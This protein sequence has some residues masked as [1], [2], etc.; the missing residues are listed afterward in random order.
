[1]SPN[2]PSCLLL[3]RGNAAK[4]SAIYGC[5]GF[6]RTCSTVAGCWFKGRSSTESCRSRVFSA[7]PQVVVFPRN[8]KTP[9]MN[10]VG[11]RYTRAYDA[12]VR[13][14][15]N[16]TPMT[17]ASYSAC[18]R[19]SRFIKASREAIYGA[20]I[21]PVA[22]V[23][24]LPPGETP[25]KVHNFDA[26]VGCGHLDVAVLFRNRAGIS[27]QDRRARRSVYRAVRGT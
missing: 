12:G 9:E 5:T 8:S 10:A 6:D 15:V 7:C 19:N 11:S 2:A 26:R 23:V 18:T 16:D 21:D 1:M 24:W 27:W 20:F 22:L 17:D 3:R 13:F 25:G 14:D 4:I